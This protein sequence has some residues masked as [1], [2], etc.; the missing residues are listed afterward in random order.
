MIRLFGLGEKTETTSQDAALVERVLG[1][2]PNGRRQAID[3][4]GPWLA[5]PAEDLFRGAEIVALPSLVQ[6][7]TSASE[8]QF[9]TARQI[10][11]IMF[12]HLPLMARMLGAVSGDENYAGLAGLS[13]LDQHPE[14]VIYLIPMVIARLRAGWAE[15]LEA[16]VSALRPFPDLADKAQHIL[17][18]P[19]ATVEAN[20]AGEPAEVRERARRLIN[21]AIEGQLDSGAN[22]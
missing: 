9:A 20:L 1:I 3:G 5:G 21:A 13:Q 8:A 14:T 16:V 19:A 22:G 6:A 11:V 2:A 15:N 17:D 12:R 4:T 18:K 7:L 10:A